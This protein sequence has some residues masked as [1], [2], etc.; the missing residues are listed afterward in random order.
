[1]LEKYRKNN[2]ETTWK[3]LFLDAYVAHRVQQLT[4]E[5]PPIQMKSSSNFIVK[6]TWMEIFEFY[7][8]K[9]VNFTK[10]LIKHGINFEKIL[11]N[12]LRNGEKTLKKSQENFEKILEIFRIIFF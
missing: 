5:T 2:R 11:E 3:F 7:F 6:E 10:I 9:N 4:L 8:E 1:M 12:F